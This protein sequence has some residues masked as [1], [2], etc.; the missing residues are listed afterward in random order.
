MNEK[1]IVFQKTEPIK[2]IS[3]PMEEIKEYTGESPLDHIYSVVRENV[4][5]IVKKTD[6]YIYSEILKWAKEN[7]YT[8][9]FLIDEDFIKTAFENELKRR[10]KKWWKRN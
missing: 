3:L 10:T 9:I 5:K 7:G 8:D 1:K 4:V 2:Y 6:D